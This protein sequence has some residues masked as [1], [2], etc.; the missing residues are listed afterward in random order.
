MSLATPT[1]N[2]PF[3]NYRGAFAQD[4]E[5]FIEIMTNVLDRGAFIMQSDVFDFEKNLA[6][7]LGV[8]HAFGLANGTDA[9]QIGLMAAGLKQGD[10]VLFPS[11]TMVATPAAIHMA[12]G[13]P[14]PVEMGPD[15]MMDPGDL[16]RNITSKTKAICPVQVNGRTCDMDA[17]QAVCDK[18]GLFIVE[19]AAQGLGSKFKG[20]CAGTFGAAGTFSFYPAKV[21][22][23][24][25]DGG[26]LVTNDD[27]VADAVTM[28]RDHG[29]R[30]DGEIRSWG[31]NS[32]LDNMQAAILNFQLESYDSVI[33]RRRE[34]AAQYQAQLGD[35]DRVVLPPG[36][37]NGDHF[38]VYQNYELEADDRDALQVFLKENG[39]GT[40]IQWSGKAVHQWEGLGMTGA[41][42]PKTEK[43]FTRCLMIP[44]NMT[45]TDEEVGYVTGKIREFYA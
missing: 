40:L 15:H 10:E 14:V 6:S 5:K 43:F 4:R 17:I 25:G 19:D 11:H 30:E 29:R 27:N 31:F 42:L 39:I 32:R 2:V 33:A 24:F 8:K 18:Y 44:M 36:P 9:I 21:L 38:D 3:F 12:G 1:R 20:R 22:G 13:I 7:Y 34:I 35:F 37:D 26:G 45:I 41:K 23:C 28:L 16:E